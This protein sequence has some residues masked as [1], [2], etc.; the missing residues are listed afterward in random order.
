[1]DRLDK[2]LA[3]LGYGTRKEI[4]SIVKSGAV[5]IDGLVVKDNSI[6]INKV[7]DNASGKVIWRERFHMAIL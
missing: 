2:I 6:K 5:K 3:N 7:W 4:K 1:M